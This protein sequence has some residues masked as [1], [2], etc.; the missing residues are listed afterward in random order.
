M[1]KVL[2]S[3]LFCV[4][5]LVMAGQNRSAKLYIDTDISTTSTDSVKVIPR[6]STFTVGVTIMNAVELY[7]FQVYLQF[8]TSRL[9]YISASQGN[10]SCPN[11]LESK[12]AD[13]IFNK[14]ISKDDSTRILLAG[15]IFGDDKSQCAAG[16]G[17]LAL[18]TFK[19]K[20]TDTT[21]LK[22]LN[23]VFLDF[24]EA[25]DN[26]LQLHSAMI[27]Q[28]EP[29]IV[30]KRKSAHST[31]KLNQ[32]NR[33]IQLFLPDASRS[34]ISLVDLHGRVLIKQVEKS[35]QILFDL[36]NKCAG[37]YIIKVS[38]DGVISTYPLF[39]R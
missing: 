13:I 3:T 31:Q 4:A 32:M 11:I 23:P 30:L 34:E 12:E 24:D 7:G 36:T 38:Q 5:G 27:T 26:N 25:E 29:A 15:S 6:D 10:S 22:L 9:Q 21:T 20:A 39:L 37:Y 2:L 17:F 8:D 19:M 1:K 35:G 16:S 18:V 14:K 28:G 33:K